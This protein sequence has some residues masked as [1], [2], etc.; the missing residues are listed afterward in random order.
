[1]AKV[2]ELTSRM[3]AAAAGPS[4]EAG[5]A[6]TAAGDAA[7]QD[8]TVLVGAVADEAPLPVSEVDESVEFEGGAPAVQATESVYV[9]E[10]EGIEYGAGELSRGLANDGSGTA[11]DAE[12]IAAASSDA[13]EAA[14]GELASPTLAELYY[15][16][17]SPDRAAE[18]YRQ[19][20]ARDPGNEGYRGR[21]IEIAEIQ[22][23]M[24]GGGR[25]AGAQGASVAGAAGRRSTI[26]RQIQALDEL[27]AAVQ[28]ARQ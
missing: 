21:L 24:A 16:Q 4:G 25:A 6:A 10:V 26:E 8:A 18:I 15:Q 12:L 19:L 9:G 1:L 28:R 5:G 14:D 27:L 17:G 20:L 7:D 22:A 2:E 23:E 11:S 13:A 3:A